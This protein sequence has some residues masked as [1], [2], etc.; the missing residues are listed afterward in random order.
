MRK[1]LYVVLACHLAGSSTGYAGAIADLKPDSKHDYKTCIEQP[2]KQKSRS[3]ELQ[4]LVIDDQSDRHDYAKMNKVQLSQMAENDRVRRKRVGEIFGEGCLKSAADFNAAALI[5]QHGDSPEHYYQSFLWS[6]RALQLGDS[7]NRDGVAVAIDRYLVNIGHKQ[8]FG[9][10]AKAIPGQKGCYCIQ[11]SEP[12]VPE[13]MVSKYAA[14]S[15]QARAKEYNKLF[16]QHSSCVM[17]E[18][19]EQLKPSPKGTVPGFW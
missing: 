11:Q 7:L 9:T 17:K 2:A 8:L 15:K 12:S 16:N 18:C 4:I 3:R 5:F 10:Q 19:D 13:S 1:L 14:L 6:L